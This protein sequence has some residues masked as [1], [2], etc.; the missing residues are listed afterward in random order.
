MQV[1][2]RFNELYSVSNDGFVRQDVDYLRRKAGQILP[3]F[4]QGFG[5]LKVQ[6]IVNGV[7]RYVSVHRMVA[8]LFIPNPENKRT[9]NHKDGNS[10]NN[11]VDNLEWMTHKENI[12]HAKENGLFGSGKTLKYHLYRRDRRG[13][14]VVFDDTVVK[15]LRQ[16]Y[17]KNRSYSETA[18]R[19][20]MVKQTVHRLINQK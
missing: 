12:T 5:Y 16:E 7:R 9:V 14:P 13:A 4:I 8:E 2:K 3:Q 11:R 20:G 19:F 18:R 6:I 15:M 10:L 1:W 17:Q